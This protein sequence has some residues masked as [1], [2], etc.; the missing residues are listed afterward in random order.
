MPTGN[1]LII[2]KSKSTSQISELQ[3]TVPKVERK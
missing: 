1:N 2:A 3:E